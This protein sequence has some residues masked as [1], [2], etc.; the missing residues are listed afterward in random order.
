MKKVK[1]DL[2]PI[3][4]GASTSQ[5]LPESQAVNPICTSLKLRH[6]ELEVN[7]ESLALAEDSLTMSEQQLEVDCAMVDVLHDLVGAVRQV[8]SGSPLRPAMGGG[9]GGGALGL[10]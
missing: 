2:T 10:V 3:T 4:P 5:G 9:K 7:Q 6:A 1:C 8:G